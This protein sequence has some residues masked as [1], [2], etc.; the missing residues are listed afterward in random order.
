MKLLITGGTGFVGHH[1]IN[2]LLK[3]SDISHIYVI[4][5]SPKKVDDLFNNPKI[6]SISWED[7]NYKIPNSCLED[8]DALINLMG[9]NI[10][11]GR[12]SDDKKER[13]YKSRVLSAQ[14]IASQLND[15]GKTLKVH[16]NSSAIGI[17]PVNTERHIIENEEV[18][19]N[20]FLSHVCIDWENA[21]KEINSQRRVI[22]RTGVVLGKD[23]GAIK[24]MKFPFLLGVG[25]TLGDGHQY[26][27]WV[28]V[29]DLVNLIISSLKNDQYEGT[30]N[31]TSPDPVTNY[32]FTKTIGK[33]ISRPTLFPV[34]KFVLNTLF[35]EM[36]S[37][38][39]DD[40]HITSKKLAD[41]H[42]E[43]QYPTIEAAIRDVF[44]KR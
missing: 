9:E 29:Q 27:S 34:P 14:S 17:Y 15:L 41:Y 24:K 1:L 42:F 19:D 11:D 25:G 23:G 43:F 37:I 8:I 21:A 26:M 31:A 40:Q 32:E 44:E 35:G 2:D 4:S 5:R 6:T 39:L 13:I 38:L 36:S 3:D 12:W 33:V 20:N 30:I 10:S 16:V 28:H 18:Y 7:D 22:L